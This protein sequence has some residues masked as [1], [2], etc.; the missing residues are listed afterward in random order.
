[1]IEVK[2]A[3]VLLSA[4]EPKGEPQLTRARASEAVVA[5]VAEVKEEVEEEVEEVVEG[6][7]ALVG[8]L[9]SAKS[10]IMTEAIPDKIHIGSREFSIA[11]GTTDSTS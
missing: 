6:E 11:R 8:T 1:M 3:V 2:V 4:V 10:D 9:R 5:A 7:V